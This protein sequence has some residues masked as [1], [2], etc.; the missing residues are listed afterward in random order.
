MHLPVMSKSHI[1]AKR[2][3]SVQTL[4]LRTQQH[5]ILYLKLAASEGGLAAQPMIL[6]DLHNTTNASESTAHRPR[7]ACIA[8]FMSLHGHVLSNSL[9]TP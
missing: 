8:E 2:N 6:C 9:D 3:A 1:V 5:L 4:L 7:I